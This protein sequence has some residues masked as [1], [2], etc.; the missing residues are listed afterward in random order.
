MTHIMQYTL[1][2]KRIVY[3]CT[4][5]CLQFLLYVAYNIG[6]DINVFRF[7]GFYFLSKVDDL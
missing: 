5:V 6:E 4:C 7:L 3:A 1:F 2:I